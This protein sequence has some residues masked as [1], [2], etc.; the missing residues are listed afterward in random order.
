MARALWK[1]QI[2][3]GLVEIPVGLVSAT[4]HDDISFVQLDSK[5]NARIGYKKYNKSTGEEVPYDRIIKAYELDDGLVPLSADE[6]EKA[7]P[8]QTSRIEIFA[9]VDRDDIPTT[10]YDTPYWLAPTG[11]APTKA[12]AYALLRET[13]KDANKVGLAKVVIR[14][15][16]YL[17][18][19]MPMDDVLMLQ[20]MR[21]QHEIR[22]PKELEVPG[23]DLEDLG[24]KKAELQMARM[25]VDQLAAPFE[26]KAYKDEF[27]DQMLAY[28]ETKAKEGVTP[29]TPEAAPE[30]KGQVV[31][32][33]ELL[34]RS[35]EGAGGK[36]EASEE[37]P[38]RK[39]KG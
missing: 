28:I 9:F 3:F 37:K 29:A 34:K 36:V 18:A 27:R 39:A 31:D 23:A 32:I 6:I 12:K 16:Q 11:K 7:L 30:K 8:E 14:T 21:Y 13:L 35:V 5:D 2:S 17:C 20:T 4:S 1:G 22:N 26:P 19:V 33:F 38:K 10:F 15:R 25:L 24:V